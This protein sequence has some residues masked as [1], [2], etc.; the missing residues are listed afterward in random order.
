MLS[1]SMIILMMMMMMMRM[2]SYS[3][4]TAAEGRPMWATGA[5]YFILRED[6]LSNKNHQAERETHD[7]M[8]GLLDP[9]KKKKIRQQAEPLL[10]Q[11]LYSS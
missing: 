6:L 9:G 5:L 3:D 7:Q 2:R 4:V 8:I 10:V 11:Q 1:H